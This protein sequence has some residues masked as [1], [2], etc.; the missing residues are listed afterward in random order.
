MCVV[1]PVKHFSGFIRRLAESIVNKE[2]TSPIFDCSLTGGSISQAR[3]TGVHAFLFEM[4]VSLFKNLCISSSR[5]LFFF[6]EFLEKTVFFTETFFW[7]ISGMT[8]RVYRIF[9]HATPASQH[10]F[11]PRK[12]FLRQM[13]HHS[14]GFLPRKVLVRQMWHHSSG[15]LPR[16]TLS[17]AKILW[18]AIPASQLCEPEI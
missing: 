5:K 7:R 18:H 3:L 8:E 12:V 17:F 2:K 14:T 16:K 10:R 1:K 4:Y 9:L 11:L 6:G 15:F 13:L